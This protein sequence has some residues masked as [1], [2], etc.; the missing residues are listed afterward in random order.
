MTKPTGKP[1]PSFDKVRCLVSAPYFVIAF[2]LIFSGM[3]PKSVKRN[4]SLITMQD[5][6]WEAF[7]P[8]GAQA[9]R[10]CAKPRGR[11]RSGEVRIL[12]SIGNVEKPT[13]VY[14]SPHAFSLV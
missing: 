12:D 5:S 1:L 4:E 13:R 10:L 14:R 2:Q 7:E 6:L 9:I 8:P 11:F 3:E